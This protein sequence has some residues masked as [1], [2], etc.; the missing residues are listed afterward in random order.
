MLRCG[1]GPDEGLCAVP[2]CVAVGCVWFE[3]VSGK[4]ATEEVWS[5]PSPKYLRIRQGG[6][7]GMRCWARRGLGFGGCQYQWSPPQKKGGDLPSWA[8]Y[9]L[10]RRGVQV[11]R[12]HRW[13]SGQRRGSLPIS[14]PKTTTQRVNTCLSNTDGTTQTFPRPPI[15]L[16]KKPGNPTGRNRSPAACQCGSRSRP[17]VPRDPGP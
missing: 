16:Q 6:P 8:G 1:R 10:K 4:S 9:E 14:I 11:A 7:R 15:A 13:H 5:C 17:A 12:S 3:V 2:R